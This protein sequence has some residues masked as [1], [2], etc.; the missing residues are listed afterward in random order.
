MNFLSRSG[1]IL[2]IYIFQTCCFQAAE[3]NIVLQCFLGARMK[4]S[5][6]TIT[7][8]NNTQCALVGLLVGCKKATMP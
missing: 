7:L 4:A 8:Y 5:F 2:L 1:I 3:P 6:A